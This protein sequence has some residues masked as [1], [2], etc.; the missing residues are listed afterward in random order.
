MDTYT[1]HKVVQHEISIQ[2]SLVKDRGP[3]ERCTVPP[4]PLRGTRDIPRKI[5]AW[6]SCQ[7]GQGKISTTRDEQNSWLATTQLL[8]RQRSTHIELVALHQLRR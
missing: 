4:G 7:S 1:P 6:S 3:V 8:D 5:V 2:Q